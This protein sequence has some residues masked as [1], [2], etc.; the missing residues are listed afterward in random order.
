MQVRSA[1]VKKFGPLPYGG[2]AC[3]QL[4]GVPNG[5]VGIGFVPEDPADQAFY[6]YKL[7][8]GTPVTMDSGG[9]ILVQIPYKARLALQFSAAPATNPPA[10]AFAWR[11][12]NPAE[13]A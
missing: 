12:F 11:A 7:L 3:I 13:K 6:P 8:D 2:H 4:T 9:M 5:E 1:G 10:K